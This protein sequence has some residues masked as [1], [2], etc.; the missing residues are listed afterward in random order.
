LRTGKAM[1]ITTAFLLLT[2]CSEQGFT[3]KST[4][5]ETVAPE[6]VVTPATLNFGEARS[7]G[8]VVRNFTIKNL[9]DAPLQVSDLTIDGASFTLLHPD[10]AFSVDALDTLDIAVAFTPKGPLEQVGQVVVFSNDDDEPETPVELV[11]EGATPLLDITSA[12]FGD[13]ELGC[14]EE[15]PMWFENNGTEPLVIEGIAYD[16]DGQLEILDFNSYPITLDSGDSAPLGIRYTADQ[17]GQAIGTLTV[18]SNDPR[19]DVSSDQSGNG[20]LPADQVDSFL[21]PDI[22]GD[23]FVAPDRGT[24]DWVVANA[25]QDDFVVATEVDDSWTVSVPYTDGFYAPTNYTDDF[26]IPEDPPVD[27]LFAVDQSCSMDTVT[28]PLGQAFSSFITEISNVT[29]DWNIGVVTNDDGCFNRGVLNDGVAN[30][31]S[32]FSAAVSEGGCS[33]GAPYCNTESLSILVGDS[34]DNTNGC[35]AGFLRAGSPLHIIYVSD[36]KEQSGTGWSSWLSNF[37]QH[38]DPALLKVSVIGDLNFACGEGTGAV[39]YEEMAWATGGETLNV[40]NS[41][42]SNQTEDL[43]LASLTQ[44]HNYA[45][46]AVPSS[47]SMVVTVDGV[48]WTSGYHF[49]SALNAVVFDVDMQGG[50]IVEV[51]Y[52]ELGATTEY[53]LTTAPNPTT[54]TVTVNGSVWASGWAYNSSTQEIDFSS[55]LPDGASVSVSYYDAAAIM[56]YTLSATPDSATLAVSVDG[57]AWTF[58]WSYDATYNELT[59]SNPLSA[60]QVIDASYMVSGG[61]SEFVLS[62]FPNQSTLAVY[63]DGVISNDWHYETTGNEVV[64]DVVAKGGTDVTVTYYDI[65]STVDYTLSQVPDAPSIE[66]FVDG[67]ADTDWYYDSASNQIVFTAAPAAGSLVTADYLLVAATTGYYL[68]QVPEEATL[69]VSVDGVPWANYWHYEGGANAIVFDVELAAGATVKVEY[70]VTG[71]SLDYAL[72]TTPDDTTITVTIDG[73]SSSDWT[74]DATGNTLSLDALPDVGAVIEVTY[75]VPSSCN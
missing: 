52:Q 18:I 21:G 19:G 37:Q 7:D 4:P 72:S 23:D 65:Y 58:G 9:G 33:G 53:P 2:G 68:T 50:Q 57:A 36:E 47:A 5:P 12:N 29:D 73:V 13:V 10:N 22:A 30:Y 56:S 67:V 43:A 28:T 8:Q 3:T 39:G 31:S 27:I 44:V 41:S 45:L 20:I 17:V 54:I 71:Q 25:H 61:D 14:L 35:N 32:Q 60:G 38:V 69:Q 62:A 40:C 70:V 34:L 59:F 1:F 66:V 26:V 42:W 24:D 48:V 11:G 6:I 46:S 16:S 64:L 63:L 74:Y 15:L 55:A 51:D 49:D 75:Y